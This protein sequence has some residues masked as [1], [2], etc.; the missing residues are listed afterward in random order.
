MAMTKLYKIIKDWDVI[1]ATEIKI[2]ETIIFPL[3]THGSESWT[4]RK[5]ERGGKKIDVFFAIDL[6]K[7]FTSTVDR[8]QNDLISFGGCETHKVTGSNNHPIKSTLF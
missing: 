5:K 8:E 1:K 2:A 6:E 4:V 7:N 3:L